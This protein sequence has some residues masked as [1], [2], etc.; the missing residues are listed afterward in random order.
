MGAEDGEAEDE[1]DGSFFE[2]EEHGCVGLD[3]AVVIPE[4]ERERAGEEDGDEAEVGEEIGFTG[5]DVVIDA[6]GDGE[7]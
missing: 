7:G 3:G 1:R 2:S 5:G 4:V 6:V